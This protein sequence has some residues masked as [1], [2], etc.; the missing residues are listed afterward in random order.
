[1]I[2]TAICALA[3]GLVAQPVSAAGGADDISLSELQ[4][5]ERVEISYKSQGCFHNSEADLSFAPNR[6]EVSGMLGRPGVETIEALSPK[7]LSQLDL[8]LARLKKG[9]FSGGCTTVDSYTVKI[10]KDGALVNSYTAIDGACATAT[11]PGLVSPAMLV[12]RL[13]NDAMKR[14]RAEAM[15]K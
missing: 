14:A 15:G 6:V 1:M 8:Y 10:W 7:E 9:G 2:K 5:G 12:S 11:E 3:I 13:E 4:P